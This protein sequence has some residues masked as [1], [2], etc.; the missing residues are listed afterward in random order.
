MTEELATE[1]D[2]TPSMMKKVELIDAVVER[3]GVKK[4]DAKPAIEAAL[5]ILGETLAE[6]RGL[7][8]PPMG[9]IKFVNSKDLENGAQV[10]TLKLRRSAPLTD[11]DA[12]E[13]EAIAAE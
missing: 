10:L 8:L 12:T 2:D 3:T 5:E 7:S 1:A 4:R 11:V 13:D 6:G 9:K